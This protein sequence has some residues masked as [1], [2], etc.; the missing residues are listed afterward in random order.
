MPSFMAC[1][2]PRSR[3]L[4]MHGDRGEEAGRGGA[5]VPALCNK[6]EVIRAADGT[7]VEMP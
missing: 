4:G 6:A 5:G 1:T 3:M 7:A 2:E